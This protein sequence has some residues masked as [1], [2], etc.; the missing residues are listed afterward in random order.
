MRKNLEMGSGTFKLIT[1]IPFIYILIGDKNPN[2]VFPKS[3][4]NQS[5]TVYDFYSLYS[6]I[7]GTHFSKL[8]L[9]YKCHLNVFCIHVRTLNFF[10]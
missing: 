10:A 3:K 7:S 2:I 8:S 4:C 1:G 9:I 5:C 6:V